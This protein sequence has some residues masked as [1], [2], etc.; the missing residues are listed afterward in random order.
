M[1]KAENRTSI[2]KLNEGQNNVCTSAK[3]N[4]MRELKV[5]FRTSI[6][7]LNEGQNNVCTSAK[8]NAMRELKVALKSRPMRRLKDLQKRN[9]TLH[10]FFLVFMV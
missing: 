5:A 4:A 8:Q 7:K 10:C 2:L 3:Q 6:L 1:G 9:M